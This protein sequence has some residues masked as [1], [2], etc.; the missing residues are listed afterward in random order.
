MEGAV[1]S[2][3]AAVRAALEDAARPVAKKVAAA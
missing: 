3:S 2:G 1:R